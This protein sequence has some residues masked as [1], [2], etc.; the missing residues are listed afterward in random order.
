MGG[1]EIE[2]HMF[3]Q[4]YGIKLHII[5]NFNASGQEVIGHQLVGSSGSLS[6]DEHSILYN[7]PQIIQFNSIYFVFG[8]SK[9]V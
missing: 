7:D 6:P 1:P 9:G 4:I 2:G 5:E 3:C 8:R